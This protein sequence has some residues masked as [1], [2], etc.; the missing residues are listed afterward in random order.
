MKGS[1]L[2]KVRRGPALSIIGGEENYD[3][4]SFQ[5]D[6]PATWIER[7]ITKFPRTVS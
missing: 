5:A 6:L 3:K 4:M 7:P 1:D 2:A